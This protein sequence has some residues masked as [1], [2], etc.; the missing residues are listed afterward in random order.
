MATTH[1]LLTSTIDE[2]RLT[3]LEQ[4]GFDSIAKDVTRALDF[5]QSIHDH[6]EQLRLESFELKP[7]SIKTC[8][9]QLLKKYPFDNEKEHALV[10]TDFNDNFTLNYVPIFIEELLTTLLRTTLYHIQHAHHGE[11]NLWGEE[12]DHFYTLHFKDTLGNMSEDASS[13]MFDR[14]FSKQ[15]DKKITPGLGLCRLALLLQGGDILCS[16]IKGKYTDFAI[17][18]P[19]EL[20]VRELS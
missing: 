12:D 2:R 11:I 7:F 17:K 15:E 13:A 8:V 5:L 9:D 3:L 6:T 18:F 19:K 14:F 4:E 1:N 10:H 20:I 16:F